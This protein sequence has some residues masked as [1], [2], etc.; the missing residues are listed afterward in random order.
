MIIFFFAL[1]PDV[2]YQIKNDSGLKGAIYLE[3][4]KIKLESEEKV[5]IISGKAD[6]IENAMHMMMK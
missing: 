3:E 6:I 5:I 1:L 4:P 2:F